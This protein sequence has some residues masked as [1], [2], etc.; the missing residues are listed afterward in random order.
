[1]W[2]HHVYYYNRA[3]ALQRLGYF[4]Q[5]EQSLQQAI[6]FLLTS[7]SKDLQKRLKEYQ[8]QLTNLRNRDTP[9]V[10]WEWW[11]SQGNWWRKAT[12]ISL[13]VLLG[14]IVFPLCILPPLILLN[15]WLRWTD[16][17][18][19]SMLG[20]DWAWYIIPMAALLIVLLSPVI[21]SISAQGLEMGPPPE[22]RRPQELCPAAPPERLMAIG[23][24]EFESS[25]LS[26]R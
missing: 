16:V 4:D 24:K 10:W 20:R 13:L 9:L 1:M 22:P 7:D 11:I 21:R 14:I 12:G 5:A 19:W 8:R 17:L 25:T 3:V 15:Y 6:D 2:V 26:E 23:E 18:R